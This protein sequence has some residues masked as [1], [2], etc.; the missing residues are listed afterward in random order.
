MKQ[1]AQL[2]LRKAD[3]TA[4]IRSPASDFQ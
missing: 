2:W 3:C 1:E 4:Y